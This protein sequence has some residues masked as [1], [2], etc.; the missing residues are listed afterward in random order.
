[1]DK[2]LITVF[3]SNYSGNCKAFLQL[4]KNSMVTKTLQI[5]YINV[6]N[7]TIRME[8]TKKFTQVPALVVVDQENVSLFL[9]SNAF[10]WVEE[11]EQRTGMATALNDETRVVE[12]KTTP[13]T[14][15]EQAAEILKSRQIF[16][17]R[18]VGGKK[19]KV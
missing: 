5:K 7:R 12:E 14:I 2:P 19:E 13:K 4:L 9:G 16:S 1:M 6:D 17:A 11:S 8:V 15:S 10:D 3:Y 18:E